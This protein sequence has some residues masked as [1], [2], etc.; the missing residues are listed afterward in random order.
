[1]PRSLQQRLTKII[2]RLEVL[3]REFGFEIGN[4]LS[5]EQV[6]E[7]EEARGIRLP[8]QYRAFIQTVGNG[9]AG[10][11]F[12]LE[13]FALVT[14]DR[15]VPDARSDGDPLD[16]AYYGQAVVAAACEFDGEAR[17]FP[18]IEVLLD[19]DGAQLAKGVD[20][21]T[22]RLADYGCGMSALLV[23]NGP[24]ADEVWTDEP[25]VN[26]FAP[27]TKVPGEPR[28]G[29]TP[30]GASFLDWYEHWLDRAEAGEAL[31]ADHFFPPDPTIALQ[32]R[33]DERKQHEA[34]EAERLWRKQERE[35][36]R[37]DMRVKLAAAS[38][39]LLATMDNPKPAEWT[40]GE[41][42][43]CGSEGEVRVIEEALVLCARC[44][45]EW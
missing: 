40:T 5:E 41:C 23:L 43:Q 6:V 10:P 29:F 38:K 37:A 34:E 22:L 27:F 45:V 44:W 17:A 42:P 30:A 28:A 8:P 20:D 15:V 21:G 14:R 4:V 32:Q 36:R 19:N 24:H 1:M 2:E 31:A 11:A 33:I 3:E 16:Y 13:R 18:G 9:G 12:G 25:N 35:D 39:A 26:A 7:I